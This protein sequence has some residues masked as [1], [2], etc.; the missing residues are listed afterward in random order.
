MEFAGA[1]RTDEFKLQRLEPM[2]ESGGAALLNMVK[3]SEIEKSCSQ[4]NLKHRLC[5]IRSPKTCL[6]FDCVNS[7]IKQ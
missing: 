4:M 7:H 2:N 5:E 3:F 6:K 1:K